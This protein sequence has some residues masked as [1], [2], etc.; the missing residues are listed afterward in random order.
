METHRLEDFTANDNYL[1]VLTLEPD[2]VGADAYSR[3]DVYERSVPIN[4][5]R[6]S[7][8]AC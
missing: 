5:R 2:G 1:T 3:M 4:Y 8:D 7:W 6:P